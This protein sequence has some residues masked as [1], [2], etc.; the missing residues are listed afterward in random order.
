M[1]VNDTSFEALYLACNATVANLTDQMAACG[2][3]V[4]PCLAVAI[5]NYDMPLHIAAVF[6]I[7]AASLIGA[8]IPII[9]KHVPKLRAFPFPI[10]VGKCVGTGVILA[11]ALVHMLQPSNEALSNACLPTTF[12]QDYSFAYAFCLIALILM[13]F[14]DFMLLEYFQARQAALTAAVGAAQNAVAHNQNHHHHGHD[15]G[16]AGAGDLEL[17][18]DVTPKAPPGHVHDPN[19]DSDSPD[20]SEHGADC[21][22]TPGEKKENCHS[23]HSHA[24]LLEIKGVPWSTKRLVEAYM[25]EFGV[26]VHSIFVGLAVG[27]TDYNA[28]VALL[29]AF[30]FHQFF[31]GI[32]LGGEL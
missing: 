6:I 4:D 10:V 12:S 5:T 18:V 24:S 32:A 27:V 30:S 17:V 26:T 29:I 2:C 7:L 11:C 9:A 25:I 15:H 23:G 20:D 14:L 8:V 31:E 22:H 28:L 13:H 1:A 19:N 21:T 3:G 16:G